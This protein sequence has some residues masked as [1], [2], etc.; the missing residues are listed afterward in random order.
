MKGSFTKMGA[1]Y[2]RLGAS[3]LKM[4]R[5]IQEMTRCEHNLEA[6]SLK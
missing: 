4:V 3:Y 6:D 2:Q 5:V 1:D